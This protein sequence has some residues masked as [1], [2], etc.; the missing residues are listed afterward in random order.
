MKCKLVKLTNIS[1]DRA[2]IYSV[3]NNDEKK[4]LLDIFIQENINSFKS[5]INDIILRLRIM[6]NKTGAREN[7]F[8]LD[9]GVPTDGVCALY[10]T[11][12]K[13]LRLYCIRYGAVLLIVG[14]GGEKPKNIRRLQESP[15]LKKEN[16]FLNEL[17][18]KI[19]ERIKNGEI[20]YTNDGFDLVGDFEFEL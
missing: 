6:G 3:F 20:K 11:P 8:K 1:G 14:G 12:D 19:T 9:E 18:K 4:T 15:K 16:F 17:S 2:S 13:K 7:Y 10:D 5:E